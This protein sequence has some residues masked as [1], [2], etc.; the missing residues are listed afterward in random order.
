M[1]HSDPTVSAVAT[2]LASMEEFYP[3]FNS[4]IGLYF[5][6]LS[7]SKSK[8]FPFRIGVS[9]KS[10]SRVTPSITDVSTF[11]VKVSSGRFLGYGMQ[12][13]CNSAIS[14]GHLAVGQTRLEDLSL[15]A[16]HGR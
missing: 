8:Y 7:S 9:S 13:D 15:M 14:Q 1:F 12:A 5:A 16:H 6:R 11:L 2:R 3:L 4:Q 10:D